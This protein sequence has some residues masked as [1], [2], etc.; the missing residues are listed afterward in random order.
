[1]SVHNPQFEDVSYSFEA[2]VNAYG[3]MA[4]IFSLNQSLRY[5]TRTYMAK[6]VATGLFLVTVLYFMISISSIFLFGHA[7]IDQKANLM[8]NINLMYQN[9]RNSTVFVVSS[10]L[11]FFFSTI[12]FFH[13]PFVFFLAKDAVMLALNQMLKHSSQEQVSHSNDSHDNYQTVQNEN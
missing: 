12:L 8:N 9:D 7:L 4:L 5:R 13:V 1:M 11:R 10:I 3:F 6:S 2:I